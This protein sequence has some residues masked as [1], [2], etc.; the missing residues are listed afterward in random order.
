MAG[1][2]SLVYPANAPE[3]GVALEAGPE[4]V[5]RIGLRTSA[6]GSASGVLATTGIVGLATSWLSWRF[7]SV[8][9]SRSASTAD[10]LLSERPGEALAAGSRG[11]E[12]MNA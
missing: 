10:V 8:S 9:S 3:G 11:V 7:T 5:A 12:I 2:A 1:V 4:G 6:C